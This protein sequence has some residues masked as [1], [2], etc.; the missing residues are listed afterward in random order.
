MRKILYVILVAVIL[1][2]GALPSEAW[3]RG[4]LRGHVHGHSR[5][6]VGGSVVVGPWWGP[7]WWGPP[8]P[9]YAYPLPVVV[10]P[11]PPPVYIEQAP[12]QVWYFCDNPQGYYPDVQQCP[13]GW[14]EI[15]PQPRPGQ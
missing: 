4:H 14:R 3:S 10:Q 9:Y 7:V 11:A 8:Y 1:L 5:V 12:Q 13:G 6:F 2:G 15:V